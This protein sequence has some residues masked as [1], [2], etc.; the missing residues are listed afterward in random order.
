M[1]WMIGLGAAGGACVRYF[2]TNLVKRRIKIKFPWA[3]LFLNLT[4][5]LALGIITGIGLS[6]WKSLL[7]GTGFLG[8]YTT[9]S[10]LNTEFFVLLNDK[11]YSGAFL[12][13]GLSYILGIVLAFLGFTLGKMWH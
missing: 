12:Y 1:L 11:N 6:G 7:I 10:T 3:T 4:G 9:F 2:L 5:A 13:G 8:G